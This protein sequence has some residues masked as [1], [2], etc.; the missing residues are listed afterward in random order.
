MKTPRTEPLAA[1]GCEPQG[2]ASADPTRVQATSFT[3]S[4]V[5]YEVTT[6]EEG[7]AAVR[8][9]APHK[10]DLVKIWLDVRGGRGQKIP[11]PVVR[12]I[13]DEATKNG[14]RVIAHVRDH[15]DAEVAVGSGV[16]A[17]AHLAR[18]REMSDALVA[19]IVKRGVYVTPTLTMAERGNYGGA[20][21]AWF[22]EPG[23][24]ALSPAP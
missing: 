7:R 4:G 23:L 13:V 15:G 2:Q 10:P 8:D 3:R 14:L 6:E 17:L 5:A 18:D 19:D 22:E 12:A 24:Q 20:V 1:R 16:Y 21:P 11:P 9:I